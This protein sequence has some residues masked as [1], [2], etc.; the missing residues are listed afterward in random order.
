MNRIRIETIFDLLK[1]KDPHGF[2]LLNTHHYRLMYG[3]AY[4][5]TG[6]EELSKDTIQ[7]VLV[8]L[9]KLPE[10]KYPCKNELT[11]LYTVTKNE[12]LMLL[13]KEKPVIDF[14]SLPEFEAREDAIEKYIDLDS[15]KSLISSLSDTQK[16]VVTMKILG[17]MSHKEVA[18]ALGKPVGTIQW[19]Y[20]TSIKKLRVALSAL[21]VLALTI[22]GSFIIKLFTCYRYIGPD[23]IELP[24]PISTAIKDPAFIFLFVATFLAIIA[25]V[26]LFKHSDK[27]PL[28]N[29]RHR[30]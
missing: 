24:T 15:F 21:S 19:I 14:E 25:W 4:S 20:N 29:K 5:V 17:G 1:N 16:N 26:M 11:W 3:I 7:N 27:I 18:K 8:R 23:D 28:V 10:S 2:E 13:R 6:N 9:W 30:R 22:F 12:A